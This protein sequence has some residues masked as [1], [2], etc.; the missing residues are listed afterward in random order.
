MKALY[1]FQSMEVLSGLFGLTRQGYYKQNQE[2]T[3]E[4]LR[5]DIVL[6]LVKEARKKLHRFGGRA[7]LGKIKK[8]LEAHQIQIGRDAFFNLLARNGLLVKTRK[9]KVYTT[10]SNHWFRKHP[11][12]LVDPFIPTKAGQLWVSDI[13][14]LRV[15]DRFTYLALV[16]DAYS[17]KIVGYCLSE[18]LQAD[19]CVKALNM[20]LANNEITPGLIH[21]SDRGL[22]YCSDKYV[23]ILNKNSIRI[24]MTQSGSPYDNALAERVN[25]IIKNDVLPP[26]PLISFKDASNKVDEAINTYNNYKPHSSCNMLTP[27]QAHQQEGV[28]KKHWKNYRKKQKENTNTDLFIN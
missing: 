28:L 5:E 2:Q 22:Q 25:G 21:H 6:E 9:R 24:S 7:L 19:L 1:P 11:N 17:R 26:V 27:S 12:L 4:V 3:K 14:Y 8:D 18:S 16:T 23:K 15:V 10:N 13:T 20:A